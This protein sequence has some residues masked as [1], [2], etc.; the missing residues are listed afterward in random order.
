MVCPELWVHPGACVGVS[1]SHR[2]AGDV[3]SGVSHERR[4]EVAPYNLMHRHVAALETISARI[5]AS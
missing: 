1:W 4:L 5:T 2:A 3:V